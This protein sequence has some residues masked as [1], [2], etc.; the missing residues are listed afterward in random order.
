VLLPGIA[1]LLLAQHGERAAEAA[2]GAV[3]RD[4][5]VDEAAAAGDE[6]VGEFGAVF[7]GARLDLVAVA[8]VAAER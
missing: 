6:G 1:E 3:R 4:H 8:D 2:A 5:V 7:L